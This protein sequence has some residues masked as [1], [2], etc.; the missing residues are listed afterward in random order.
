[1]PI[2]I[3]DADTPESHTLPGG[4]ELRLRL[5]ENPTTGFRWHV[6]LSGAGELNL[7]DDRYVAGGAAPGGGGHRLL[8][9]IARRPG[10]VRVEAVLRRPW[11]SGD[12]GLQRR[13]FEI[14]VC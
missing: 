12:A 8:R 5:A 3:S 4:D 6:G 10:E 2:E 13:V 7:V 1:M 9:F 11:E 14:L